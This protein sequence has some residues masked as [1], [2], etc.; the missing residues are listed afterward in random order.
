MK[1]NVLLISLLVIVL[2]GCGNNRTVSTK[3][4]R[5]NCKVIDVKVKDFFKVYSTKDDGTKWTEKDK[6]QYEKLIGQKVPRVIVVTIEELDV[7]KPEIHYLTPNASIYTIIN[8][9][10]ERAQKGQVY[11]VDLMYFG[12]NPNPYSGQ[13][14]D[15]KLV[16]DK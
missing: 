12:N 6:E 4:F 2:T 8:G 11:Y 5:G 7:D 16:K 10:I 9:T 1:K 13:V 14:S 3:D 15:F